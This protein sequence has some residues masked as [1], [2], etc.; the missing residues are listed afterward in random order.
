MTKTP[1][2]EVTDWP[3]LP[4][5]PPPG[6]SSACRFRG[7]EEQRLGPPQPPQAPPQPRRRRTQQRRRASGRR[8]RRR[9]GGRNGD[10]L[11]G[12]E[13]G[14]PLLLPLCVFA[15]FFVLQEEKHL[16]GHRTNSVRVWGR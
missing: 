4:R 1:P 2:R 10:R 15:Q 9:R 6:S 11:T 13:E 14:F 16:D 12:A 7:P 8:G 3:R 5:R